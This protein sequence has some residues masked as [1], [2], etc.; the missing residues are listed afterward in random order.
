MRLTQDMTPDMM[1]PWAVVAT[2]QARS[3]SQLANLLTEEYRM[4]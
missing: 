1:Q 2:Y 4:W 3:I